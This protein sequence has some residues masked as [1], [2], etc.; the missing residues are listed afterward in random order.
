MH[1]TADIRIEGLSK[2]E[3]HADLEIKVRKGEVE[4][5]KL[6]VTENKRFYTQAI[7]GKASSGIFQVVSRIC[8]TCSTAHATCCIEALENA[9]GVRPSTQ[10]L[11]LRNLHMN[12]LM[13]RDHALHL[14]LFSLPDVFG[15]DSALEFKGKHHRFLHDAFDVKAAGN[16][17]CKV[18]GGRAVHPPFPAIGGFAKT[19]SQAEL[20]EA[21]GKLEKVRDRVLELIDVFQG[22]GFRLDSKDTAFV[23][24]SADNYNFTRGEILTSTG[25]RIPENEYWNH[26]NRVIIPYSQATGFEFEGGCYFVGALAR[27]NLS[28]E[29]L[30]KRTRKDASKALKGF[31]SS[32]VFMNNLAQAIEILHSIDSSI[33]IIESGDFKPE[34]PPNVKPRASTGVGVIE[35]PR[36]TLYYMLSVG[37]DGNVKYGNLV[38]PT[39]Q[40]QRHMEKSIKDLV[41][42]I[43]HKPRKD[44]EWEIEKLIRAYDPCMSCAAHFLR[45][46]W[47]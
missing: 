43:L 25:Q 15:V 10:A 22:C 37:A 45:V 38:I 11:L 19:P 12:G 18:V 13:V 35:A 17:L 30:N 23:G 41:P 27:M 34:P 32:N 36:G 9:F 2:I 4:S 5:A 40:N 7:R 21:A 33:E 46:R 26:L 31:P 8:G 47:V 28:K 6:K 1:K 44:V 29:S 20:R 14:Y 16:L 39:A 24:L 3:G 42:G